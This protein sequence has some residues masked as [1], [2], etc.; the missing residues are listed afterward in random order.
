MKRFLVFLL[1]LL[2]VFPLSVWGLVS[3]TYSGMDESSVPKPVLLV[4][5]M[6]VLPQGYSWYTPIFGGLTY[7]NFVQPLQE[8]MPS[9]GEVADEFIGLTPPL[10][11]T[12]TAVISKDG[13]DVWSGPADNV[14]EYILLESGSYVL[15]VISGR[16]KE[17]GQGYGELQYRVG[18]SAQVDTRVEAG[19]DR[20]AQGDVLAVQLYNVPNG[21]QVEGGSSFGPVQFSQNGTGRYVAYLSASH[22]TAP[23][24]YFVSVDVGER[25]FDVPVQVMETQFTEQEL[26]IDTSSAEITEANSSEAY[27]EYNNTIPP[28]FQE[29]D[30]TRYWSG[31]FIEPTQGELT[32]EY[33]LYRY[34]NGS[35][36]ASR[37][38]G[39]DLSAS[40]GT[41]VV[42]PN[43]G[44]VILASELLNT[45][46]TVVIE[47]GNGLKSLF[48]HLDSLD[49]V[50]GDMVDL[51]DKIGEVGST[52]YSTGPHLHYE[53]RLFENTVDPMRLFNG[54]SGLY[55]FEDTD[56]SEEQDEQDA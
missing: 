48:Y 18:F 23:G 2:I 56:P 16:E 19:E 17:D 29:A 10:G 30:S 22:D 11:F 6:E 54:T 53:V 42:A 28:L 25:T 41:E 47:H 32:T 27:A 49:V 12:S 36:T 1:I 8:D 51:G 15:E 3:L 44:R 4:Q 31:Q 24:D 34:T 40:R 45:G 52:G 43:A 7:K 33:G 21:A 55:A 50:L 46:N 26:T 9:L 5:D 38:A 20:I 35:S 14:S 13:V 37:H 39:I